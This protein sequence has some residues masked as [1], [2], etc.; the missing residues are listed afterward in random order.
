MGRVGGVGV[1]VEGYGTAA[2]AAAPVSGGIARGSPPGGP[3]ASA[4][5]SRLVRLDTTQDWSH[6]LCQLSCFR[7]TSE[8]R[9]RQSGGVF[10]LFSRQ[11]ALI[12]ERNRR[13]HQ[14]GEQS[15]DAC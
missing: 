7:S 14:H 15:C 5:Y 12:V 10:C 13:I 1:P 3:G 2:G 9:L 8:R 6:N 11:A 4:I